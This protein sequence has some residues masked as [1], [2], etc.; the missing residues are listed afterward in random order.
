MVV[1]H[2]GTTTVQI[3]WKLIK[4][5]D[6]NRLFEGIAYTAGIK[7]NRK[8]VTCSDQVWDNEDDNVFYH[9][10]S[11]RFT[12]DELSRMNLFGTPIRIQHS[13]DLPAIGQ[14]V[15]NWTDKKTGYLHILGEIPNDS[16]YGQAAISL[17]DNGTCSELSI[18]YPLERN[19]E[20]MEVTHLP[21]DEVSVVTKGHFD[22]CRINIRAS[23][24]QNH[25]PPAVITNFRTVKASERMSATPAAAA[26]PVLPTTSSVD[27]LPE[28][29]ANLS[30]E[31]YIRAVAGVKKKLA[32]QAKKIKDLE[33]AKTKAEN[34]SK[35]YKDA[36]EKQREDYAQRHAAE[37]AEVTDHMREIAI[38]S[39]LNAAD[40][41]QEWVDTNKMMLMAD[42]PIAKQAQAVQ[43]S[44][45]RGFRSI[46]ARLT[47]LEAENGN[48]KKQVQIGAA[49]FGVE[50][51][52]VERSERR[53]VK[54]A[55]RNS[56]A[57]AATAGLVTTDTEAAVKPKAWLLAMVGG[58]RT[59]NAPYMRPTATPAP[60][61]QQ[62]PQQRQLAAAAAAPSSSS[63]PARQ[64]PQEPQ[65]PQQQ[66][67]SM[68]WK[69]GFP[70]NPHSMRNSAF[71]RQMW[72]FTRDL[73]P[74]TKLDG[75]LATLGGA[76]I[77]PLTRK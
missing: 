29:G 64:Q 9:D 74:G 23:K 10:E 34:E 57:A 1:A 22:N 58:D 51:D 31:E 54:A 26:A 65:Q 47:A 8:R 69:A 67:K 44:C 21:V 76:D 61:Q 62:A 15:H 6:G 39:G 35:K 13:T 55:A 71:N 41:T 4:S 33:D 45:S 19:P 24:R 52:A 66:P 32:E 43:V 46:K 14:I 63:A 17:I 48:L 75:A 16:R 20:T 37:A 11:V 50:E 3:E 36:E 77:A 2:R 68:A 59:L 38:E 40:I 5:T 18:S 70:E 30:P 73:V 27:E 72:E 28:E 25:K 42:D 60:F 53:D 12:V 7:G 56:S 49:V